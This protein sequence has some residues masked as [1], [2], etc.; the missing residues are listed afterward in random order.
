[1][2][3]EVTNEDN[4]EMMARYPDNFWDLAIV[5]PP[6]GINFGNFNRTN[7]NADGVRYKSN[8]YHNDDWDS[9]IPSDDYFDELFR[10]SKNQIIWGGNYFPYLWKNGCKSYI[11]WHKHQPVSNFAD[12]ELAWTSFDRPARCFDYKYFGNINSEKIRLRPT[13]KPV[14]LYEWI[15]KNYAN[16][17]DKILDTHL[18]SGSSRIAAYKLKFDFWGCEIDKTY[19]DAANKRFDT[20]TA[21]FGI[22]NNYF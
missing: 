2:M 18:G 16:V 8:R 7:K 17:H 12:G 3:G 19:F 10:V 5:D 15:L 22:D 14:A 4:M 13:Q 9:G 1:M 21:A 20:E 6:Y 11:F